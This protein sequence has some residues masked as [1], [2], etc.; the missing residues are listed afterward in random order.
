[1]SQ[2]TA[3]SLAAPESLKKASAP[4]TVADTRAALTRLLELGTRILDGDSSALIGIA[5]ALAIAVDRLDQVHQSL[6]ERVLSAS[7]PFYAVLSEHAVHRRASDLRE[8]DAL[9][10]A[11]SEAESPSAI[12]RSLV[13]AALVLLANLESDQRWYTRLTS[14]RVARAA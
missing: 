12:G 13:V 10:A 14:D 3:V 7:T 5:P 4:S 9:G 8:F 11:I 6:R 2:L 1:M